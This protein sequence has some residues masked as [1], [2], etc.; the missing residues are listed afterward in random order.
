MEAT[1]TSGETASLTQSKH[2]AAKGEPVEAI[3]FN[4]DTS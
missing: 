4:G 2:S 1:A 3:V